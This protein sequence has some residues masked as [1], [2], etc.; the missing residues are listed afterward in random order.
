MATI[1]SEEKISLNSR[2]I[3]WDTEN[4][5][6]WESKEKVYSKHIPIGLFISPMGSLQHLYHF[7]K[8]LP[9]S[10]TY[11]SS[12]VSR[13]ASLMIG[14]FVVAVQSL[15]HI[16]LFATPWTVA[17]QAP[18]SFT[19]SQFPQIYVH[20]VGPSHLLLPPSS[21]AFNLSQHQGLFQW[22]SSSHQV[23]KVLELQHQS[24]QWKLLILNQT[25]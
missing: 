22:V 7:S 17:H 9:V 19:I 6:C 4:V 10:L 23:A 18:L 1:Q 5:E 16:Q 11:D 21:F 15:S 2:C 12:W 3:F 8:F 25:F 20:W 24:F 13:Y 14:F